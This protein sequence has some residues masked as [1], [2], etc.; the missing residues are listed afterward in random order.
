MRGNFVE[1]HSRGTGVEALFQWNY[2]DAQT[3]AI[4]SKSDDESLSLITL[5]HII[6]QFNSIETLWWNFN[7]LIKWNWK[8]KFLVRNF[9][10]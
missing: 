8:I 5:V 10:N 1:G 6:N 2:Y 4:Y 3:N 7:V 9:D